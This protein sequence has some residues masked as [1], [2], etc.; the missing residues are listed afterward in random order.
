V[1]P[2]ENITAE[3][4][5]EAASHRFYY[6]P[7]AGSNITVTNFNN[8]EAGIPLGLTSTWATGSAATGTIKI[9]LRHYPGNPPNKAADDTVTST[10][11]STDIEV[12]FNTRVQ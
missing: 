7:S 10:K 8:D 1:S 11:S 9:T 2:V 4:A 3:V 12:D 5:A 6:Q